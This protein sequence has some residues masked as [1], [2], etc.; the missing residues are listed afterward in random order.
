MLKTAKA[1]VVL[2][3]INHQG[4]SSELSEPFL[5]PG[6]TLHDQ[7]NSVHSTRT[8]ALETSMDDHMC[9]AVAL[10]IFLL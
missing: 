5:K 1:K 7:M 3:L 10:C 2:L 9:F 4:E 8:A 6:H